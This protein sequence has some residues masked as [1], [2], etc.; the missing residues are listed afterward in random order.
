MTLMKTWKKAKN[1]ES[2]ILMM[3]LMKKNQ[4]LVVLKQEELQ[5]IEV[6]IIRIKINQNK[7]RKMSEI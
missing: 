6:K 2:K 7:I 3:S 5:E 1:L 4:T